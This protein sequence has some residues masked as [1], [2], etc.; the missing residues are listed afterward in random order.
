MKQIVSFVVAFSILT[1]TIV[2]A[3]SGGTNSNGCHSGTQAY[4]C[5]SSKSDELNW[6]AMA[7]GILLLW[8]V[9]ILTRDKNDKKQYLTDDTDGP[10]TRFFFSPTADFN[11]NLE[12]SVGAKIGVDF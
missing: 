12:P 1:P 2:L 11:E 5:H 10:A 9:N 3:H 8:V 7:A 4:H 6:E